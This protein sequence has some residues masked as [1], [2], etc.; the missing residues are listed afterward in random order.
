MMIRQ[1]C[2]AGP[3]RELD[4]LLD[5]LAA[6]VP[7]GPLAVGD[8]R[9]ADFLVGFGRTL[10]E[11]ALVRRHPELAPLGFFLRRAEL[12]AQLAR[13]AEPDVAGARLMRFPRGLVFHIPPANVDTIFVYAWALAALTG[14]RNVVRVS[15]R[16]GAA[17]ELVL[18]RLGAALADAHPAVAATQKMI[19][20]DRDD[21]A[22]AALSARCD[23]R[24][25]WGGDHSVDAV[26]RAPLAPAARDLTFPDRAS[27]AVV[28]AEGWLRAAPDERDRAV[29]DLYNDSYWFDQAACASPRALYVVGTDADAAET[30]ADLF[31]RLE[32]LLAAR[33][34][35]LDPAMAVHKRVAAYGEAA[36]GRAARLDFRAGDTLAVLDLADP[37]DTPRGW[38]GAGAFPAATLAS[39][40]DLAPMLGRRDQTL[41]HFGFAAD[42]LAAFAT[43]VAGRGIDRIVPFGSALSFAP[44]WD[45]YDLPRE[46]TRLTTVGRPAQAR[47]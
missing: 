10:L 11:P 14:N 36:V 15:P 30:R 32:A 4:G 28:S 20:Y 35:P 29:A 39:L 27:Y 7:G 16:S 42:E 1:R 19:T 41:T 44:V 18:D 47:R 43:A 40:A 25:V 8:P 31:A 17:A 33:G 38:L 24:V 26:R 21:R 45:G 9:I 12:D 6:D 13:I 23:L 22:T 34:E 46:F 5:E 2:P 3:D 37:L